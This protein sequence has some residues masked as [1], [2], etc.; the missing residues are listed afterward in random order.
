MLCCIKHTS[1]HECLKLSDIGKL[2]AAN[3]VSPRMATNEQKAGCVR[4]KAE[5]KPTTSA[6]MK[7]GMTYDKTSPP[8]NG[9]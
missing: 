3:S 4:C 8:C 1:M 6:Q 9:F 7:L 2:M 5:T